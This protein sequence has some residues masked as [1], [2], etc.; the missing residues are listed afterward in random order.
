MGLVREHQA[1]T[2][3]SKR[4]A[5]AAVIAANPEAHAD[6]IRATNA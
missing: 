6:F 3:L 2:G 5:M 1:K 4:E